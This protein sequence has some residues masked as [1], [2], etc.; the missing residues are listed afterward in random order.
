MTVNILK[1]D[2]LFQSLGWIIVKKNIQPQ[3][4]ER[5]YLVH[6]PSIPVKI[7][8]RIASLNQCQENHSGVISCSADTLSA[9][10]RKYIIICKKISA[11]RYV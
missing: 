11:N 5:Y 1:K 7:D 3:N 2:I 8:R 9:I 10:R 6:S 4:K